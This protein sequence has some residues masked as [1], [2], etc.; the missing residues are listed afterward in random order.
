MSVLASSEEE[1]GRTATVYHL[2]RTVDE[3]LAEEAGMEFVAKKV[4]RLCEE[5]DL[6]QMKWL[7]GDDQ[8]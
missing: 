3:L 5:V 8:E 7:Q 4:G 6:V 2:H 1:E